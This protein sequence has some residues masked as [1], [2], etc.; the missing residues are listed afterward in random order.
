MLCGC[1]LLCWACVCRVCVA[2]VCRVCV[3]CV[4]VCVCC[5]CVVCVC[6]VCMCV[7]VCVCVCACCGL[8]VCVCGMCVLCVLNSWKCCGLY[9]AGGAV[10]SLAVQPPEHVQGTKHLSSSS[11]RN[12]HVVTLALWIWNVCTVARRRVQ[13]V[14]PTPFNLGL[15]TCLWLEHAQTFPQV[16]FPGVFVCVC[17]CALQ[18]CLCCV[19]GCVC[20]RACAKECVKACV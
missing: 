12:Q 1:A 13:H 2:C 16:P 14:L 5:V 4:C 3:V 9:I 6:C 11:Q 18:P 17:L 7:C 20:C 10:Y 19:F 15:Y 8:V